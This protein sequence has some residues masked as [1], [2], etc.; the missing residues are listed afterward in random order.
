[1]SETCSVWGIFIKNSRTINA[2]A[3]VVRSNAM[4]PSIPAKDITAA[5]KTGVRIDTSE[6]E[7]DLIPLVF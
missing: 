3:K 5:A 7:N 2:A 4:T 6:F 1:M